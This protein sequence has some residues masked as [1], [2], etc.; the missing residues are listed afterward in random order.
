MVWRPRQVSD[1]DGGRSAAAGVRGGGQIPPDAGGT[2]GTLDGPAGGRDRDPNRAVRDPPTHLPGQ[3]QP[4]P[5]R[6]FAP[7]E[8]QPHKIGGGQYG[9]SVGFGVAHWTRLHGGEAS[10]IGG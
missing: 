6:A 10:L 4:P 1:P 2:R 9:D 8:A 3:L 7:V 5:E